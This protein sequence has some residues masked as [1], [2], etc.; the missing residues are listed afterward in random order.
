SA[1]GLDLY[2][3]KFKTTSGSHVWSRAFGGPGNDAGRGIAVDGYNDVLLTG[4]FEEA[5]NFGGGQLVSTGERDVC[6]VK[7]DGYGGHVWSR[8]FGGSKDDMPNDVAVDA[9]NHIVITG[10]FRSTA[11]FGGD[12]LDSHGEEDI[13]LARYDL[14][15]THIW[16]QGFGGGDEDIADAVAINPD[17]E[18]HITGH[19]GGSV[20]FGG[21]ILANDGEADIFLA[22]FTNSGNHMWSQTYGNFADDHGE[23]LAVDAA[24]NLFVTGDFEYAVALGGD[25][26]YSRGNT[27]DLF[28]ASFDGSGGHR[29]SEHFGGLGWDRVEAVATDADGNVVVT[30]CYCGSVD[31]GGGSITSAGERDIFVAKYDAAGNHLWS[32]GF[33]DITYF[34]CGM[35]V[36]ADDIGNVYITGFFSGSADFGGGTL[37]SAGSYDIFLAKYDEGGNHVWSQ[38]FGD[39]SSQ[40]GLAVAVGSGGNIAITGHC[41]GMVDFGGG[42]LGGT[43]GWNIYVA[44][45]DPSGAHQWSRGFGSVFDDYGYCIAMDGT[46]NTVIAG[47]FGDTIDFGGGPIFNH[48]GRDGFVASYNPSGV[49][50]WSRGLGGDGNDA[51]RSVA[52]DPAGNVVIAGEF[53]G[54][55]DFGGGGLVSAGEYDAVLAKYTIS[56]AHIWSQRFGDSDSDR[57]RSVDVDEVGSILLAGEFS[58]FIDL[59]GGPLMSTSG[60]DVFLAK[61][62][63]SG[64]HI[65]SERFGD[66]GADQIGGAVFVDPETLFLGGGYRYSTDLGGGTLT[67]T[68]GY[69]MFLAK[70][71]GSSSG[72]DDEDAGSLAPWSAGSVRPNPSRGMISVH[73]D[74]PTAGHT[75]VG[76]Y[77]V[78]GRRVRAIL[79]GELGAGAHEI[80]WDGTDDSGRR[81][82]AGSYMLRI[83]SGEGVTSRRIVRVD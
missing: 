78:A 1:G 18:I 30:G 41:V 10:S 59:G 42:P 20:D 47:G 16:S 35:G 34:D 26:L 60:D 66:F 45:F 36:A 51:V 25:A 76:I 61:F 4:Y 56:G 22:K 58:D 49:N 13:F 31:F 64:T 54:T 33:G 32:L 71:G 43:G 63:G 2:L 62:D 74:R 12:P 44:V 37:T 65:W 15:G 3:A 27:V 75:S 53:E 39:G 21:G 83:D 5:V 67:S 77:D 50:I 55:V 80:V 14:A 46:G 19:C 17:K 7:L 9:T 28:V 48:G 11:D 69:D 57:G 29:W 70:L 72:I 6:L 82:P 23:A 81:V 8:A 52:V 79:E 38:R 73:C 68:G 40:M 24:G